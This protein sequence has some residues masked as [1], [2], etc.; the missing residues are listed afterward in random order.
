[1]FQRKPADCRF[2][3][4]IVLLKKHLMQH[5]AVTVTVPACLYGL[6]IALSVACCP[7]PVA[8]RPFLVT[9]TFRVSLTR[10]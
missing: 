1:M 10:Q 3:L 2:L 5:F 9:V 6:Q 4:L 8:F 7:L